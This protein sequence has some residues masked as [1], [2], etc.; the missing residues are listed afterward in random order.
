MRFFHVRHN[1][2]APACVSLLYGLFVLFHPQCIELPPHRKIHKENS[3]VIIT[4]II[5]VTLAYT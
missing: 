3:I 2:F 4:I 5:I 1:V